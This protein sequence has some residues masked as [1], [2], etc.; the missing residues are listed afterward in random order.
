MKCLVI[1]AH[2]DDEAIWMGGT[3]LKHAAWEWHV[4]SLCRVDDADRAPRFRRAA[5]A[6]GVRAYISDLDDSPVLVPLS[7]DLHEIKE[8]IKLL[9]PRDFN[10]IF[11]HGEN[12]EYTRH[13]RHEQVHRAVREMVESGELTGE[14]LCFA[15]EDCKGRYHPRPAAD[16]RIRVV[17]TPQ[18]H[19]EKRRIVRDIYGFGAGSLEYEAAGPVEA[20]RVRRENR[21]KDIQIVLGK[22]D[23]SLEEE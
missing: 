15:Y 13:E 18:E 11:T 19:M 21:I 9:V 6:L 7:A 17:L 12:G 8:R 4:L 16:A 1:V 5:C 20:F 14:L 3:I 10:L 22:T 2:P 23:A